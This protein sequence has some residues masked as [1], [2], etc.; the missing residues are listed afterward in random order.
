[1]QGY[2]P[3]QTCS[4]IEPLPSLPFPTGRPVVDKIVLGFLD[5][6]AASR[7]VALH[8]AD[9]A[10]GAASIK[11]GNWNPPKLYATYLIFRIERAGADFRDAFEAAIDRGDLTRFFVPPPAQPM[12]S[13]LTQA[14]MPAPTQPPSALASV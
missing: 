8:Q 11:S 14:S 2:V 10:I 7:R 3:V 6:R 4:V 12:Y 13:L 5:E 1:G 9:L